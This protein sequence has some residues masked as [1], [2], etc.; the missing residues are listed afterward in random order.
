VAFFVPSVELTIYLAV[1]EIFIDFET[2][3][4]GKFYT[5]RDQHLE[6]YAAYLESEKELEET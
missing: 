2:W 5:R 6:R 4:Y 3:V 1:I